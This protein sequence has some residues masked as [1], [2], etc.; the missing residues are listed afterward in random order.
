MD[1]EICSLIIETCDT[2]PTLFI[3]CNTSGVF[4]DEVRK[5]SGK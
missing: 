2:E 4:L 1:G 3:T 5:M